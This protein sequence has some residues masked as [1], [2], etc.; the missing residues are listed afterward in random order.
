M[1][2]PDRIPN[3]MTKKWKPLVPVKK[4]KFLTPDKVRDYVLDSL[5]LNKLIDDMS[6]NN[7]ERKKHILQVI[8]ILKE[9]AFERRVIVLRLLGTTITSIMTKIYTAVQ[10]NEKSLQRLKDQ[11]GHQQVIYLPSHRSYADFILMS[12]ICFAH[13]IEV[14]AIA[15]GMDFHGMM[16]MGE[17]LRKTGAFFMRRTFSQAGDNLYWEIFREYVHALLTV[18]HTGLEFFVEGTRS[19][20]CKALTPKT[21]LFSM[22]LEPFFFGQIP[23]VLIVPVS[24]SYEKP[25]EE[26][27][28]V[29][30]L[31]G[32]PKPKESTVGLIKSITNLKNQN[33]GSIYF[34]FGEPFSV[35][36]YFGDAVDRF[37]HTLE[38]M[39][40]QELTKSDHRLITK[41]ANDVVRLQQDKIVITPF[42]LIALLI[43]L[44]LFRGEKTFLTH[45]KTELIEVKALFEKF[46]AVVALREDEILRDIQKTLDIHSNILELSRSEELILVKSDVNLKNMNV[47]K[48]KGHNLSEATMN[49][50]VP[51]FTLQLY[52]NPTLYWLAKPAILILSASLLTRNEGNTVISLDM[53]RRESEVLRKIF[54]YEF[55][56]YSG[57]ADQDF[58]RTVQHLIDLTI[59][60]KMPNNQIA[61][62]ASSQQTIGLILSSVAPFFCTYYQVA[63]VISQ[64]LI[65][66]EFGEKEVFVAVQEH[67]EH[68]MLTENIQN[69]HPYC[70]SLDSINMAILSFCNFGGLVKEKK[71]SSNIFT[72]QAERLTEIVNILNKY[73]NIMS[74]NYKYF[75]VNFKSKM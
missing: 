48:L 26:Q 27:L 71:N 12:Y 74:F 44:R 52:N 23:D 59:F 58:E 63:S 1:L 53:L 25:L 11:M 67:V 16:G 20:S 47:S 28:F 37:Q 19:R 7:A 66:K 73:C 5:L 70:L 36:E 75:D 15:A 10:V 57:F 24:I 43:N 30:E 38:P 6:P 49:V 62:N 45:L 14:P 50:S 55:V 21:G 46:G 51:A 69:V 32:I 65:S 3:I 8:D 56:L 54:I 68:L 4:D 9:I 40:V 13:D 33:F 42:S 29:Y 60:Q 64:K 61:F 34:D 35:R 18:N 22:A 72:A 31:M 39:H 2:A 17:L 41:L